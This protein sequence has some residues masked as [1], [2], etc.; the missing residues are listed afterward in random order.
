[1]SVLAAGQN[2]V[3]SGQDP[4]EPQ[5][6]VALLRDPGGAPVAVGPEPVNRQ[7]ADLLGLALA[8]GFGVERI[9]TARLLTPEDAAARLRER[10]S[11]RV[12]PQERP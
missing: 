2:T 7:R 8:E 11:G 6:W 9:G 12:H 10:R 1:M 3:M 5:C 4:C